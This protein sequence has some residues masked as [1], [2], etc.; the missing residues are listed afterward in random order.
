M[1]LMIARTTAVAFTLKKESALV[2]RAM[3][4]VDPKQDVAVRLVSSS[5]RK[6]G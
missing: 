1:E 5:I 3:E 2:A 4:N 6:M